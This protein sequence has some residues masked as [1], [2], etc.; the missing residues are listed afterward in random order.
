MLSTDHR[1]LSVVLGL[2]FA[3]SPLAADIQNSGSHAPHPIEPLH[4]A[5][6]LPEATLATA[7]EGDVSLLPG[8][9]QDRRKATK[10]YLLRLK[11]ENIVQNHLLEAG[12]PADR[13]VEQMHQG[14]EAPTGQLRGHF[15][16]HW[17]SAAAHFAT[18][19]HD[20]V[21]G[22]RAEDIVENLKQCQQLNGDGW[23]GSIPEK[24]F[25]ILEEGKH[26]I[27]SPQYTLHKT[28][29]GLYDDY[30]YTHNP[31]AL[32]VLKGSA[33]WFV[34]WTDK[35]IRDGHSEVIYN[36]ESAGML[37]L[38]A[39]LYSAT[40]D[41]RY[42]ELAS[43]YDMPDLFRGL[44]AGGDPLTNDHANASIPWIEGAAR[45]YEI[46]GDP[47]Y[48]QIVE[49][50]WKQGVEN[51][52]MFAT[53]GNNAGEFWIPPKQFGRFLSARTQEHCTVYNMIRVAQYLLRWTGDSRY[54]DYIE[55]A[56]Y[57]GILAQQNPNTGLVTYFL[58]LKPGS[59]KEWASETHDFWCCVGTL[60]Q[61]QAMYEDLIYYR[62]KDGVS[63]CQFIPS[64]ATFDFN[65]H[66][67]QLT[68][69]TDPSGDRANL[70]TSGDTTQLLIN[71]DISSDDA[72][73]PWTLRV[74]QPV[75][76]IGEAKVEIDGKAVSVSPSKNGFIEINR[77]WKNAAVKISFAKHVTAEPLPGDDQRFALLDGPIVLAA[78][79]TSEPVMSP[80]TPLTPQ[81]EHVY[82]SGRA[83]QSSHF[84]ARTTS[85]TET[86][87]P[88]YEV[89]D[90][91][92]AVYFA[93]PQ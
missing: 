87:I 1:P 64:K 67:V 92:Y 46:T 19:D 51:R 42:L 25:A 74:R 33:N 68:Q 61:A 3:A 85:G 31:E 45:V 34:N 13:P 79:T 72:T 17:L 76:A 66:K 8:L 88:L 43:R 84:F 18:L 47:R 30:Q 32:E 35:L 56:L 71:L 38:W 44:L 62:A 93:T 77:D 91:S 11:D 54:A 70:S 41:P 73:G 4:V 57:N 6:Q 39:D 58:P 16:G 7:N 63:V 78:L 21:T 10:A 20:V 65:G 81:Y 36:G 52:G 28:M 22:A 86:L 2:L 26:W 5:A 50:F 12:L 27:W 29:M 23:V 55:R 83:W 60:L 48:R 14:W 69:N 90:E 49:N 15:A 9:F 59:K 82:F 53:T 75:W 37:E 89:V 24:Y 80:K 40:K